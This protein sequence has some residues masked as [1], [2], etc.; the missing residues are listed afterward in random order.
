MI[1]VFP[2]FGEDFFPLAWDPIIL[3]RSQEMS[4]GKSLPRIRGGLFPSSLGSHHPVPRSQEM[5]GKTGIHILGAEAPDSGRRTWTVL[6]PI[7]ELLA[8]SHGALPALPTAALPFP[9]RHRTVHRGIRCC[10]ASLLPARVLAM[11]CTPPR[12]AHAS[13]R[14]RPGHRHA[15]MHGRARSLER[16]AL[17]GQVPRSRAHVPHSVPRNMCCR[18]LRRT[19]CPAQN[20]LPR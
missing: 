15:H 20:S 9:L 8:L 11:R 19:A 12:V 17:G 3:S 7:A 2:E 4:V 1:K 5:S 13:M 18:A 6:S 14:Y 10:R 16:R